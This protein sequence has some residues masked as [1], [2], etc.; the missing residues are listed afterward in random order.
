MKKLTMLLCLLLAVTMVLGA[1]SR[2]GDESSAAS[3]ADGETISRPTTEDEIIEHNMQ[4]L[5]SDITFLQ[6]QPASDD[7]P[8]AVIKT[9]LGDITVA[10]YPEEAPL[11]V[12]NWIALAESGYYD[13]L[14]FHEMIP[15]LRVATGDP[16]NGGKSSF[17]TDMFVDEYSLNLYH[18]NGA[19]AMDNGG[20]PD[21][22]ASKF[23]IVQCDSITNELAEEMLDVA[24][25]DKVVNQY[26]KTGG[27]PNYDFKGTVFGQVTDGMDIV[28]KIARTKSTDEAP[29]IESIT[30]TKPAG[31]GE[32][33]DAA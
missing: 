5:S 13:G 1:C 8:T 6:L 9:S 11:A 19:L 3:D 28:K 33:S 20:I 23:F 15:G 29:V 12:E 16:G 10:L 32:S 7:Q 2:G 21:A 24:F 22:N 25:P 17:E 27:V 4:V 18:F 14:R 26:L 31:Y 30:V